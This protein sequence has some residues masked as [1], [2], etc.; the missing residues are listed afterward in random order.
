MKRLLPF[1]ALCEVATS[2]RRLFPH[3]R[4]LTGNQSRLAGHFLDEESAVELKPL[5]GKRL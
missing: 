4:I 1:V 3:V 5:C 2:M